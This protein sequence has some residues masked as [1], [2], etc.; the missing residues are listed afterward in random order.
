MR[1]EV[2]RSLGLEG[3]DWYCQQ[4]VQIKVGSRDEVERACVLGLLASIAFWLVDLKDLIGLLRLAPASEVV[5]SEEEEMETLAVVGTAAG[6]ERR[7]IAGNE[8]VRRQLMG[9]DTGR[10]S[11]SRDVCCRYCRI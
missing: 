11:G 10:C 9:K 4:M 7:G 3:G 8:T 5:E 2:P 6:L 1:A